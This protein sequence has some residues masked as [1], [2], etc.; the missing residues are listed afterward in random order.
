[1]IPIS[2]SVEAQ[3]LQQLV[4][5]ITA[6]FQLQSSLSPQGRRPTYVCKTMMQGRKTVKTQCFET[7]AVINFSIEFDDLVVLTQSPHSKTRFPM[8]DPGFAEQA[9]AHVKN[10]L[11]DGFTHAVNEHKHQI[12]DSERHVDRY[13]KIIKKLRSVK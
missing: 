4:Q 11:I 5:D 12:V 1:M 6:G 9:R 10:F 3:L 8:C 2:A 13:T 7:Y